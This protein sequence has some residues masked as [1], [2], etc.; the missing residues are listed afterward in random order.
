M[1]QYSTMIGVILEKLG[2]TY[3]DL[4][5]NYNGIGGVLKQHSPE[6]RASVPELITLAELR[7]V[8]GELMHRLEERL[9]GIKE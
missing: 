3:K 5:F 7:D 4:K 6:E 2:Q 1:E 8:Y 9:P